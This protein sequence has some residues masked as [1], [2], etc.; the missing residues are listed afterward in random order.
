MK[1]VIGQ[2]LHLCNPIV[3]SAL[4]N[5]AWDVSSTLVFFVSL[6][7]NDKDK[8]SPSESASAAMLHYMFSR[9]S[10]LDPVRSV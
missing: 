4:C 9:A 1:N 5:R 10:S 2:L 6:E 7:N 8:G 3:D